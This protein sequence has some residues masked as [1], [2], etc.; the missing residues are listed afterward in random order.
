LF[1]RCDEIRS[2]VIP[3]KE[4]VPQLSNVVNN[5]FCHSGR[6]PESIAFLVRYDSGCRIT[7]GM[8]GINGMLFWNMTQPRRPESYPGKTGLAPAPG[9]RRYNG[10]FEM[11][12][13]NPWD[14]RRHGKRKIYDL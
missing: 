2:V 4:A 7:S 9:F 3:A 10:L 13:M 1:L 11:I 12:R 8:T 6:D 5:W 14:L